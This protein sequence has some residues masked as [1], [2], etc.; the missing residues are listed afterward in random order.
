[1]SRL[2][3]VAAAIVK[4]VIP[5]P[6]SPSLSLKILPI[7]KLLIRGILYPDLI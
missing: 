4:S 6:S 5:T 7:S 2:S 3:R 1:M